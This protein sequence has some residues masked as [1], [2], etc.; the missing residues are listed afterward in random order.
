MITTGKR[1]SIMLKLKNIKRNKGLITANYDPENTGDLG[2]ISLD[3]KT[4]EVVESK[5]SKYDEDLP[6]HLNHGITALRKLIK[7]EELP[8]EQLVMWY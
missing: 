5:A 4:G 3:E 6:T 1:E 8:N 7:T 2:F